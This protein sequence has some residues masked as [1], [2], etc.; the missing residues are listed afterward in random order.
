M[1]FLLLAIYSEIAVQNWPAELYKS[2]KKTF[3]TEFF[4]KNYRMDFIK[5]SLQ[6]NLQ[7]FLEQNFSRKLSLNA[8]V[9]EVALVYPYQNNK[10]LI[11]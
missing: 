7:S 4:F 10:Y 3:V 2:H 1:K 6:W 8:S 11:Y 9:S 5:P